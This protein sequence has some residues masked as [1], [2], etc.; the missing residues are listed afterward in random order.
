VR[1]EDVGSY[2]YCVRPAGRPDCLWAAE[3]LLSSTE[4]KPPHVESKSERQTRIDKKDADNDA[5]DEADPVDGVRFKAEI[6]FAKDWVKTLRPGQIGYGA[7]K[8]TCEIQAAEG[9][10]YDLAHSS[11]ERKTYVVRKA[12]LSEPA[13]ALFTAEDGPLVWTCVPLKDD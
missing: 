13:A 11:A 9:V 4:I 5:R 12:K 10:K 8:A 3:D 6:D 7:R 1:I 2:S